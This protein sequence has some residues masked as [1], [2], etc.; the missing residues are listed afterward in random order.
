LSKY[1]DQKTAIFGLR[2][3]LQP[4]A[5]CQPL[6]GRGNPVKCLTQGHTTSELTGLSSHY[7]AVNSN[8]LSL[9]IWLFCT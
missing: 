8:I 1:L 3:K 9:L 6:K 7:P 4:A 5:N 2:V